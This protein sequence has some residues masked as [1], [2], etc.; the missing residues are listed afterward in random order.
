MEIKMKKYQFV[1]STD[2]K[3][4]CELCGKEE[5]KK[6]VILKD[7]NG[8]IGYYGVCCAS[9]LL[10]KKSD[11]FKK[12]IQLSECKK[13]D[14]RCEIIMICGKQEIFVF[15]HGKAMVDDYDKTAM[16]I[17]KEYRKIVK[18]KKAIGL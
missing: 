2:E 18:I 6:T 9:V 10:G 4:Q 16:L 8:E 12:E 13:P 3:T 5:L 1:G 15:L 11:E 17:S 7:E 14:F